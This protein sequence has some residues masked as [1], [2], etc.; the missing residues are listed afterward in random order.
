[1]QTV[2][3][4]VYSADWVESGIY[5]KAGYGFV[6]DLAMPEITNNVIQNGMVSLY[7]KTGESWTPVPL[8]YYNEGF[9]GSY[10]YKMSH[11]VFSIEY[12]ESDQLTLRPGTQDFRLVIIQPN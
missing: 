12:Y 11:G 2:D 8:Q 7:M 6:V 4:T 1:M 5:G 9:Q 10:F 3:F